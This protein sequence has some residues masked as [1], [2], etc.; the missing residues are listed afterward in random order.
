MTNDLLK[1]NNPA[2]YDQWFKANYGHLKNKLSDPKWVA[3][4]QDW[5]DAN[6]GMITKL[7]WVKS[8]TKGNYDKS[9]L[10]Y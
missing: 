2:A 3:K 8:N 7:G 4:N 5:I 9:L 10:P 1:S 6:I